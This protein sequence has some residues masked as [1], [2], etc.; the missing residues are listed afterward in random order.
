MRLLPV[1]QDG[2][3]RKHVRGWVTWLPKF[4]PICTP[5]PTGGNRRKPEQA[6]DKQET[7]RRKPNNVGQNRIT[8]GK[9]VLIGSKTEYV[10]AKPRK[11]T[12]AG[13]SVPVQVQVRVLVFVRLTE[14]ERM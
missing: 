12:L 5:E 1:N 4:G 2:T 13:G 7:S 3:L 10:R 11:E 8:R 9:T 14:R 6:G